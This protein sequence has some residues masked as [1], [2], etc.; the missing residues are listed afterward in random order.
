MKGR[1]EKQKTNNKKDLNPSTLI[2]MFSVVINN[3]REMI[4]VVEQIAYSSTVRVGMPW[5]GFLT[6]HT[7]PSCVQD[8]PGPPHIIPMG[9]EDKV[10]NDVNINLK[11]PMTHEFCLLSTPMKLWQADL[12][13]CKMSSISTLHK[14]S[15]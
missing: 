15:P 1:E 4:R 8:P 7:K 12:S 9:L 13:A 3:K 5:F 11:L 6:C 2:T 10:M 14:S